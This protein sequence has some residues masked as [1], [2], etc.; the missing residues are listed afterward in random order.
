MRAAPI[1]QGMLSVQTAECNT[2]R[3]QDLE[4][5]MPTSGTPSGYHDPS[6]SPNVLHDPRKTKLS[7]A[8]D[9]IWQQDRGSSK[10]W[11]N[12]REDEIHLF[13]RVDI[14]SQ[15][16]SGVESKNKSSFLIVHSSALNSVNLVPDML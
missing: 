2:G 10:D 3:I 12:D 4:E 7:N 5:M 11:E 15:K 9:Q 13:R 16:G 8:F 6:T 1:L 14:R